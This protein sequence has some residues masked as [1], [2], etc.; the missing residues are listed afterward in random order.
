ME[1]AWSRDGRE[2]FY[3]TDA[4][5]EKVALMVVAVEASR[6][7]SDVRPRTV[8]EMDNYNDTATLRD[9]DVTPD[10]R[11]FLMVQYVD[12]HRQAVTSIHLVQ[13]WFAELERLVPTDN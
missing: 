12:R 3:V 6:G 10:G 9:Y 7:F 13:N 11:R 1:P 4:G 2:L 5:A 8:F